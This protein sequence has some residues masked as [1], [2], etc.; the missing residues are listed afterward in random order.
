LIKEGFF[1]DLVIFDENTVNDNATY[2]EPF[3]K[4]A[5]IDYVIVNGCISIEDGK[6]TGKVNGTVLRRK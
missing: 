6:F 4:P 1:A 3:N 2:I 5:G